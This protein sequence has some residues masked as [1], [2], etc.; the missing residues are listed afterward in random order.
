LAASF[1]PPVGLI[2]VRALATRETA[3]L[4][5]CRRGAA[6]WTLFPLAPKSPAPSGVWIDPPSD[7]T[8]TEIR[9]NRLPAK[10]LRDILQMYEAAIAALRA[11]H[12]PGVEALIGR[13][14]RHRDEVIAAL[15]SEVA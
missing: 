7:T 6:A 8:G 12:D 10:T 15:R 4:T 9:L 1:V 3:A 13:M 11:M 14:T 2:E 5:R